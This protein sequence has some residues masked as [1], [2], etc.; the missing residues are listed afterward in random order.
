VS[1]LQL[2]EMPYASL[3]KTF[4]VPNTLFGELDNAPCQLC[5]SEIVADRQTPP[6]IVAVPSTVE[7]PCQE[8]PHVLIRNAVWHVGVI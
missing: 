5:T 3:R 8:W 4:L 1:F 2:T 7:C 6:T